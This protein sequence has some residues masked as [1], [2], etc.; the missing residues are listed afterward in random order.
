M[1]LAAQMEFGRRGIQTPMSFGRSNGI[2]MPFGVQKEEA[3]EVLHATDLEV[4]RFD[5][6]V[7]MLFGRRGK[8]KT[9]GMTTFAELQRQRFEEEGTGCSKDCDDHCWLHQRVAANYWM[10]PA[11]IINP[12]LVEDL[13]QYPQWGRSLYICLD[14]IQAFVNNRR[15]MQRTSVDFIQF[16][17]QIRKRNN[18]IIMTTQFPQVVDPSVL[19]QIDLFNRMELWRGG[20]PDGN[21]GWH[22]DVLEWDW[23]G[24]WSGRHERKPWPPREEDA[25][26]T[27]TMWNVDLM[28][29]QFKSGQIIPP[30]WSKARDQVIMHEFG[31][32]WEEEHDLGY[33]LTPEAVEIAAGDP[34]ETI[35]QLLNAQMGAFS[36]LGLLAHA[37]RVNP[38]I[39]NIAQ[40]EKALEAHGFTVSNVDG[41]K[42]AFRA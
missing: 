28:F 24:Q 25:D 41:A 11:K 27:F 26:N 31:S 34:I 17:T 29:P 14:E 30:T 37:K 32:D 42:I 3:V 5:P 15:A 18:E 19:F 38:D 39:K 8:G 35:E 20:D 2:A 9:L 1:K 12:K 16:L 7:R 13:S 40:F 21:S 33:E 4:S 36:P 10:Q 22:I 6:T 23:W